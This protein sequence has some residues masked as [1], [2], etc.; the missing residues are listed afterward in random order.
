M[1][2]TGT[3][4]VTK[5]EGVTVVALGPEYDTLDEDLLDGVLQVLLDVAR[6]ADP[7]LVVL[8]L[9]HTR[10]FGTAFIEVIFRAWTRL[11]S[12]QGGRFC[13]SGL[14]SY[15]AEENGMPG[16]QTLIRGV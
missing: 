16:Q 7:P 11:N 2:S 9:S 14:T 13:I 4:T 8:D 6:N 15:C 3:P 5:Q 10:F 1:S 12:R